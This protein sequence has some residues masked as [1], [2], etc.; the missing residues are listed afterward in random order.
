MHLHV[1]LLQCLSIG[2]FKQFIACHRWSGEI[3]IQVIAFKGP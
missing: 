2:D 1:P 3:F